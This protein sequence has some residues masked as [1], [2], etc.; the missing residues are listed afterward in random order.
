[1]NAINASLHLVISL[2]CKH[3]LSCFIQTKKSQFQFMCA[4]K[5]TSE[6]YS[7]KHLENTTTHCF[8][9]E[10]M[11]LKEVNDALNVNYEMTPE[12]HICPGKFLFWAFNYHSCLE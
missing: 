5:V 7:S 11:S 9:V 1:M 2:I 8:L 4:Q 6:E 12:L 3:T 10:R